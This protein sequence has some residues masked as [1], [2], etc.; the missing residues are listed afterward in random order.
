MIAAYSTYI[1]DYVHGRAADAP[2]T[3][4]E[5]HFVSIDHLSRLWE[6]TGSCPTT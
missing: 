2:P 1:R 3:P 5:H 6:L 4:G